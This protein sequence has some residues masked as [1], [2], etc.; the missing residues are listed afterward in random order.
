MPWGA[1]SAM[2]W[3]T[4]THSTASFPLVHHPL[5]NC[6]DV[7]GPGS[8]CQPEGIKHLEW[9]LKTDVQFSFY[10]CDPSANCW[11]S[12]NPNSALQLYSCLS[13]YSFYKA[14]FDAVG[15][16]EKQPQSAQLPTLTFPLPWLL[17]CSEGSKDVLLINNPISSSSCGAG[18]SWYSLPSLSSHLPCSRTAPDNP[19]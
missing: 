8:Y 9:Q 12:C 6:G 11:R 2:A 15:L 10:H 3:I 4:S 1:V 5:A 18:T 13:C 17:I 16:F 14:A 19:K 7:Q